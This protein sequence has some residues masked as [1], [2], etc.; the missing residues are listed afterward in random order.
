MAIVARWPLVVPRSAGH[1][2]R[3]R[4]STIAVPSLS[5]LAAGYGSGRRQAAHADDYQKH[6]FA[7]SRRI[8]PEVCQK[9]PALVIR[10]R[11]EDRVRA[12]PAVSCA[13]CTKK[14]HTSIQGSGEH[15]AFPAQ[16][17]YG[18]YRAL[19][20]ERALLPRRRARLAPPRNLTPA[21]GRQDH[22]ASPYAQC[23]RRRDI[24]V[25]RIPSHVRDD[26]TP[27]SGRDGDVPDLPEAK[28]F[29]RG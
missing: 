20:G 4:S 16:W 24:S 10:G 14:V 29:C 9:L 1:S 12:A 15:P 26:A 8:A 27:L 28:Y 3:R 17:L 11:R 13:V 25:H 18:L 6:M 22:T 5:S 19:P 23:R 7:F 21:P 2:P